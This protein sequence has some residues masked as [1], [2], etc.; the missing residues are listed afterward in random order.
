ML[1]RSSS[2]HR[3]TPGAR[4][5]RSWTASAWSLST[6]AIWT[7]VAY[8]VADLIH[9][10]V[11][12]HAGV[13]G[14]GDAPMALLYLV[15]LLLPFALL[16]GLGLASIG[17]VIRRTPW[18]APLAALGSRRAL[19]RTSRRGFAT[20]LA[21]GA[22]L[23]LAFVC[24]WRLAKHFAT[25]YHDASLAA[26][27]MAAS[28]LGVV[29]IS[30]L[31]IAALSLALRPLAR[32]LGPFA[33]V[34]AA[35]VLMAGTLS[36]VVAKVIHRLPALVSIVGPFHF[37]LGLGAALFFFL[38]SLWTRHGRVAW[39]RPRLAL[40][41]LGVFGLL[42]LLFAGATY[43]SS[44][45]VRTLLERRSGLGL[46]LV[47]GYRTLTD[48]DGDGFSFAFGGDDCDDSNAD[49]HPGAADEPGDGVDADCFDGDGSPEV[50][51]LNDGAYGERP[52]G[53]PA[54]PNIV[55]ISVDALRPDHLSHNG[56]ARPT[57]PHLD[58]FLDGA[59]VF[60]Q[61]LAQST[62][63]MLS[64][65]SV[66]TGRYPSQIAFGPEYLW[67]TLEASNQTLAESLMRAG[68]RTSVVMGTS[69]FERVQ[70]FFQGFAR[71]Q[72]A[73][74]YHPPRP[75]VSDHAISELTTLKAAHHPFFLWVHYFTV[76]QPYL[77]DH[78]P[79][80][81]GPGSM[82]AYDTEISY[83]DTE[84]QRLLAALEDQGLDDNTIVVLASD[85]GEAFG[86]HGEQ[87]HAN[88]L[89][90]EEL[91]ATLAIRVPGVEPRHVSEPVGLFDLMPTLLNLANER[92]PHQTPSRSLLPLLDG[93]GHLPSDRMLFA[94]LMPDGLYTYDQKTIRREGMKLIWWVNDNSSQLFNLRDDPGERH[95]LSGDDL[96]DSR[97]LLGLLRAW[98]GQSSRPENRTDRVISEARLAAP[99]E[100]MGHRL[101]LRLPGHFTLLGF[102]QPRT[103]YRMGQ[104][105][106][107][108][109]YY[110]V[111]EETTDDLVFHVKILG[112]PGYAVPRHFEAFHAPMNGRYRTN[113]WKAG[114]ILRDTVELVMPPNLR[115]PVHLRLH[116]RVLNGRRPLAFADGR[117]EI[118]LDEVDIR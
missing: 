77:R 20:T 53:L 35:L 103:R 38:L 61:A 79:S 58:D 63:S 8:G 67:P 64:I 88:A 95:D 83:V 74:A 33:C 107:L 41:L 23:A 96:D 65:P 104:R 89:Y 21:T 116:L 75:W 10:Q 84:V 18:L 9:G 5:S 43:G 26:A 11:K 54:Q 93:E 27:A 105:I 76:H 57:S 98:V 3:D 19:F 108:T 34:G 47:R 13:T 7:L 90:D 32:L 28:A 46:R 114:E 59:V 80:R 81:F 2:A 68:Y 82:A 60:D 69:Y 118:P 99:P 101:D 71:K 42:M 6:A 111:D 85:H 87:F 1:S 40:G 52:E 30:A 70:G 113:Q 51:D 36:A 16:L 86:E 4:P 48:R 100:H 109:F 66:F 37:G 50:E 106:A 49:I 56:Y 12:A 62:R 97:E 91:R 110:R 102:D 17:V 39:G 45:G 55:L 25:H 115:H 78:R 112:P 72:L 73:P 29:A 92:M 14:M 31:V 94:E 24:L 44:H 15:A 117:T 22:G